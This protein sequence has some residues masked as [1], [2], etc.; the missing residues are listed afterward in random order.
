MISAWI[1]IFNHVVLWYHIWY[2]IWHFD[3]IWKVCYDTAYDK[4]ITFCPSLMKSLTLRDCL[5]FGHAIITI[6]TWVTIIPGFRHSLSRGRVRAAAEAPV[7]VLTRTSLAQAAVQ[8]HTLLLAE[9]GLHAL[10][11]PRQASLTSPGLQPAKPCG[12]ALLHCLWPGFTRLALTHLAWAAAAARFHLPRQG[13]GQALLALLPLPGQLQGF[14]YLARA[15][16]RLHSPHPGSG[17][18]LHTMPGQW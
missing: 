13:S 7:T 3:I 15:P 8:P 1:S 14:N 4:Y 6:F 11:A 5:T 16:A 9:A 18:A 17:W 12:L 2:H 10:R